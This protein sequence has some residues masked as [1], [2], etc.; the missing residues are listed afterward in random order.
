MHYNPGGV[1]GVWGGVVL[2]SSTS[3]IMPMASGKTLSNFQ[4]DLFMVGK[5]TKFKGLILDSFVEWVGLTYPQKQ[6][7]SLRKFISPMKPSYPFTSTKGVVLPLSSKTKGESATGRFSTNPS[8]LGIP[9]SSP[10]SSPIQNDHNRPELEV[11]VQPAETYSSLALLCASR[12]LPNLLIEILFH[13]SR[14]QHFASGS[15]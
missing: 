2:P 13:S 14:Q 6:K 15:Q 10:L 1:H 9:S 4:E 5:E 12:G 11:E 7:Y 3:A 8:L